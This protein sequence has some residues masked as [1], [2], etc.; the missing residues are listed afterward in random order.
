MMKHMLRGIIFICI[1]ILIFNC[2]SQVLN[3][4]GSRKGYKYV[5]EFYKERE[6][7]L[8]AIY[9]GSSN[10]YSFWNP[11]TAWDNYGIS[12]FPYAT[13]GQPIAAA[14]YLI[15]ETRKTQPNAMFILNINNTTT[16][17]FFANIYKTILQMPFS[18]NK[19]KL[20]NYL[21]DIADYSLQERLEFYIPIIRY[22]SRW[23]ELRVDDFYNEDEGIKGAKEYS[24]YLSYETDITK[25]YIYSDKRVKLSDKLEKVIDDLLD[26]CDEENIKILFVVVPRAESNENSIARIN[27][28]SDRIADRGYTVLNLRD[29]L[30]EIG[31]NTEKDFCNEKHLNIHGSIKFTNYFSNYLIENYSFENKKENVQYDDWNIAQKKY[32]E[33]Y[34]KYVIDIELD[35][36]HRDYNL[37]QPNNVK[38]SIDNKINVEWDKTKGAE[39]YVI[40]KKEKNGLWQRIGSTKSTSFKDNDY[41]NGITYYY[42]V[43]PYRTEG[44]EFYYGEFDYN[45][46]EI[47]IK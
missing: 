46:I 16:N 11:I 45:G 14:K 18:L 47:N 6:N 29:K 8:D 4:A 39:G 22:H 1:F 9:L 27:S 44:E 10:C 28:L 31:I 17:T 7:S 42:T 19:I 36:E 5:G 30:E 20:I 24:Q 21:C 32:E 35:T 15:S 41:K 38:I 40:Y 33:Y 26:Y 34:R 43:I 12:I 13:S 3:N 2:V 23:N 25:E 37:M